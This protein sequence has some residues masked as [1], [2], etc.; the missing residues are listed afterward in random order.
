MCQTGEA[1]SAVQCRTRAWIS[2]RS[3]GTRGSPGRPV[4]DRPD[5]AL[6]E[7]RVLLEHQRLFRGEVGEE[8]GD[9][10]VGL[11]GDFADAH[12]VVPALQEEPEGGLRDLLAGRRL[13]AFA[14]SG[15][16]GHALK[17]PDAKP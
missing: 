5:E 10:H 8:R 11:G 2:R 9:G 4:G 1:L 16:R 6:L 17:L 3:A 14:A 7:V 15:R 13:L 12:R